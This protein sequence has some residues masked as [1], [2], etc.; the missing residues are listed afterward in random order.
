MLEGFHRFHLWKPT[1]VS[2]MNSSVQT[3]RSSQTILFRQTWTLMKILNAFAAVVPFW[4]EFWPAFVNKKGIH[5]PQNARQTC[6]S[7][8]FLR[9]ICL[10]EVLKQWENLLNLRILDVR[11]EGSVQ[12]KH[13]SSHA[14]HHCWMLHEMR[15]KP[16][17]CNFAILG[18]HMPHCNLTYTFL[19][20]MFSGRLWSGMF[21]NRHL[22]HLWHTEMRLAIVGF[23]VAAAVDAMRLR[24]I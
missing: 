17:V 22:C 19:A 10:S 18:K 5:N 14:A 23:S 13:V 15:P 2:Q 16:T 21:P 11:N 12:K 6:V 8:E 24:G 3:S 1:K 20:R 4:T 9:W 7:R